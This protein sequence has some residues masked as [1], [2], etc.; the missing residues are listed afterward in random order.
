MGGECVK[1]K[2]CFSWCS[3]SLLRG[4]LF[5][6]TYEPSRQPFEGLARDGD[7]WDVGI[8]SS[9]VLVDVSLSYG[10]YLICVSC[11]W[12]GFTADRLELSSDV[13]ERTWMNYLLTPRVSICL[14]MY[15]EDGKRMGENRSEM[16]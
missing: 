7:V 5:R 4:V 3:R 10:P 12:R 8:P 1:T 14:C 16:V 2:V 15:V 11:V 6:Q 13:S 9:R